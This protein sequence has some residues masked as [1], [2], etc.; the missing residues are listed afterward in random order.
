[1]LVGNITLSS[2][3]YYS[4]RPHPLVM[5]YFL[6]LTSF[7]CF[8]F[9]VQPFSWF[10]LMSLQEW[11]WQARG[12]GSNWSGVTWRV[13]H[14]AD[15]WRPHQPVPFSLFTDHVVRR[16]QQEKRRRGEGGFPPFV[17]LLPHFCNVQYSCST[18]T[19]LYWIVLYSSVLYLSI[20]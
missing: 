20:V 18:Y 14:T 8:K 7:H 1:M 12:L 6:V 10:C 13:P 5:Q 16:P 9:E 2:R 15:W 11:L 17:D 4:S 19:F 3:V